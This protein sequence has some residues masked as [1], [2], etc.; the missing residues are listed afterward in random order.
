MKELARIPTLSPC[1]SLLASFS[2][3]PSPDP[4]RLSRSLS[5][6]SVQTADMHVGSADVHVFDPIRSVFE[7]ISRYVL[8]QSNRIPELMALQGETSAGVELWGARGLAL[9]RQNAVI[10][11]Q[12]DSEV[13]DVRAGDVQAEC[14]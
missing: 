10:I 13:K 8:A 11:V 12:R 2:L 3:P 7:H 9:C 14:G 6:T 5:S 4:C 1:L